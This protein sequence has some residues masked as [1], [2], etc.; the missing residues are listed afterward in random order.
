MDELG[1]ELNRSE[2][3]KIRR[4]VE[5]ACA[6]YDREYGCLPLEGQFVIEGIMDEIEDETVVSRKVQ[7]VWSVYALRNGSK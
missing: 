7:N 5:S 3:A 1:R 2:K 4:A 6:N